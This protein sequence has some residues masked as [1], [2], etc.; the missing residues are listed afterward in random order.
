MKISL[1]AIHYIAGGYTMLSKDKLGEG[2]M[3][4]DKQALVAKL[5]TIYDEC[6]YAVPELKEINT[7]A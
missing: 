7:N 2:L 5:M 6:E 3:S 4:E 1:G